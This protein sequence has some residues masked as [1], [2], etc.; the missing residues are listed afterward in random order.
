MHAFFLAVEF[1]LKVLMRASMALTKEKTNYLIA[2]ANI[3]STMTV[4]RIC[5]LGHMLPSVI[6]SII[7]GVKVLP[8]IWPYYA[9]ELNK[10]GTIIPVTIALAFIPIAISNGMIIEKIL[11]LINP[12]YRSFKESLN[13]STEI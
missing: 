6:V 8:D 5:R 3:L 4:D 2:P 1:F 13:D 11:N 10:N 9:A 7:V 12:T